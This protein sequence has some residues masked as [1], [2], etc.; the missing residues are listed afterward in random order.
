[1]ANGNVLVNLRGPIDHQEFNTAYQ[2]PTAAAAA[3]AQ[4]LFSVYNPASGKK[5]L[6]NLNGSGGNSTTLST[7]WDYV[8]VVSTTSGVS[9]KCLR[10]PV[11]VGVLPDVPD[12]P[13]EMDFSVFDDFDA[14]YQRRLTPDA[15]NGSRAAVSNANLLVNNSASATYTAPT[16]NRGSAVI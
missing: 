6:R 11:I 14:G 1:L 4:L 8:V 13:Q 2:V 10:L 5:I 9:A 12:L 15:S 16:P 7:G 3:Q